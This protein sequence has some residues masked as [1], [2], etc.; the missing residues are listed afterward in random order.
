MSNNT[1]VGITIDPNLVSAIIAA[2]VAFI[3]L[4]LDRLF[5]EPRKWKRRYEIR[6]TE[7][8]LEVY[9]PIVTILKRCHER[10]VR[11]QV[12]PERQY[13]LDRADLTRL[14]EIFETKA[15]MLSNVVQVSW[16]S[17]YAANAELITELLGYS[18][19][20][21][22]LPLGPVWEIAERDYNEYIRKY[23]QLS[24]FRVTTSSR[25]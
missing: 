23:N 24:E 25:F 19:N 6:A 16:N 13:T 10:A 20:D 21:V 8:A 12:A 15:F 1:A 18:S 4:F 9:G 5:I 11:N 17:M 7:K 2:V 22:D 14:K 3:V